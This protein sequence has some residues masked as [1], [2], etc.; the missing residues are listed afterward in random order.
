MCHGIPLAT[1]RVQLAFPARG[2]KP[3]C[4]A[5][6]RCR[7]AIKTQRLLIIFVV[8]QPLMPAT[9]TLPCHGHYLSRNYRLPLIL[10]NEACTKD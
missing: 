3:A 4:K 7:L 8:H 6:Q 9:H 10:D 2:T 5:S 1:F